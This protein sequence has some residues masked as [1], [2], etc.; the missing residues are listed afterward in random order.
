MMHGKSRSW[1]R[2][3]VKLQ[4]AEYRQEQLKLAAVGLA[5]NLWKLNRNDP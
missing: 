1:V 4:A 5:A 3:A 2:E